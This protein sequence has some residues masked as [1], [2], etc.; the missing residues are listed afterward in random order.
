M[1]KLYIID[2][3]DDETTSLSLGVCTGPA[4]IKFTMAE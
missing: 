1:I 3:F 2:Q 4:A